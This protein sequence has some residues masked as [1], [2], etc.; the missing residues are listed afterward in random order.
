MLVKVELTQ[1]NKKGQKSFSAHAQ[2]NTGSDLSLDSIVKNVSKFCVAT[3]K[4]AAKTKKLGYK[5]FNNFRKSQPLTLVLSGE[6]INTI[7]LE[8]GN[9]GKFLDSTTEKNLTTLFN[10]LVN[11]VETFVN[12]E[13][14]K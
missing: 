1:E 4:L 11:H 9:F 12:F 5:G 13:T 14:E 2:F 7:T 3:N 8:F 10:E 6:D